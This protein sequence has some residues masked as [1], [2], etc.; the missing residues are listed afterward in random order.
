MWLWFG[1][2]VWLGLGTRVGYSWLVYLW[3]GRRV[4]ISGLG[5]RVSWQV[6]LGLGFCWMWL[7]V[8]AHL[9]CETLFS[10]LPN[11]VF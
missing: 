11:A 2:L 8:S 3:L 4:M 1:W 6:W 9:V 10:R 5:G 7:W